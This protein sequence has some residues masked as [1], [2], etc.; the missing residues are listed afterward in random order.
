MP[1]IGVSGYM[2]SGKDTV[3]RIIQYLDWINTQK[4]ASVISFENML[5]QLENGEFESFD[6]Y[7][8]W[9]NVKFADKLKEFASLLINI[10]RK[11][12]EKQSV[13]DSFLG[14]E[15]NYYIVN[16]YGNSPKDYVDHKTIICDENSI[17]KYLN[18]NDH[19][20]IKKQ[21]TVREC[22][23]KLGTD[24]IR[25]NLHPNSWVNALI[26]NYNENKFWIISDC[27]FL[28]EVKAIKNNG[29]III[30]VNRTNQISTDRHISETE[31]DNYKFDYIINNET[32]NFEKLVNDVKEIL[33]KK[34]YYNNY[35]T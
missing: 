17:Y 29:G 34:N 16:L 35:K 27:R 5:K 24:A 8:K 23:Q 31:L 7:S 13:K 6:Q 30:R 4:L 33:I 10:P 15:W 26:S 18:N 1:L 25:N 3:T 19:Q 11:D 32:D 9:K 2:G 20:I 22:L 12:L 28:N 14:E 21:M